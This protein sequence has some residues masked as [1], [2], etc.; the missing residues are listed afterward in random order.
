MYSTYDIGCMIEISYID[1]RRECHQVGQIL[2]CEDNQRYMKF[3]FADSSGQVSVKV[4]SQVKL[5]KTE[6]RV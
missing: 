5:P 3:L 6:V 1:V 4:A 2:P